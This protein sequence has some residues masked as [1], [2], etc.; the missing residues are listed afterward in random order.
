LLL[1]LLPAGCGGAVESQRGLDGQKSDLFILQAV[2]AAAELAIAGFRGQARRLLL[3][4]LLLLLLRL[5]LG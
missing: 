4:L 3:L 5:L 2:A 1:L